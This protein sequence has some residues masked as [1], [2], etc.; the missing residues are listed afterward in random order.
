MWLVDLVLDTLLLTRSALF[1]ILTIA[2]NERK[3]I[4][5]DKN[6]KITEISV[7]VIMTVFLAIVIINAITNSLPHE[8]VECATAWLVIGTPVLILTRP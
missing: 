4:M 3:G 6:G 7:L 8:L 5:M 1:V 2:N